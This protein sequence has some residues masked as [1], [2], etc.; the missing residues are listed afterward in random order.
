MSNFSPPS[1]ED[2]P[3]PI[4]VLVVDDNPDHTRL[5]AEFLALSGLFEVVAARDLAQLWQE[6]ASDVFDIILLDYSL[7]DGNGLEALEAL[8]ARG[9]QLPIV[10]V[11]G[12]GDERVAAQAIQRG[13]VD[14]LV[15][16]GDYLKILPALIEKAVRTQALMMSNQLSLEKVRY[17]A[18]LLD[19]IDDAV[20][21]WD[22]NNQLTFW[23]QAAEKLLGWNAVDRIGQSA[24]HY[25]FSVFT[26]PIEPAA[27]TAGGA[28]V[29]R[30]GKRRSGEDLWVN[31][32]V[33]ELVDSAGRLIGYLDISRDITSRKRLE[34]QMIATQAQLTQAT[35]L[36][37]VGALATSV[38]HEM[39]NPL[40]TVIAEAQLLKRLALSESALESTEAIETAGLRSQAA[41]QRLLQHAQGPRGDVQPVCV[42]ETIERALAIVRAYVES[43]SVRVALQLDPDLPSVAGDPRQLEDLWTNLLLLA[44]AAADDDRPHRITIT[45]SRDADGHVLVAVHDDGRHIPAEQ[46]PQIF[47]PALTP[48]G[49][50]R[51]TSLELSLCHEIVERHGGEILASSNPATGTTMTVR[52]LSHE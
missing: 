12:R 22:L 45:S 38:A 3:R 23:N 4:R 48:A 14:Y 7:P 15:K 42:N 8:P 9:Y 39:S 50:G 51:G 20:V 33:T 19:N 37:A 1:E 41:V 5:A 21:V 17:Q 35:R 28:S 26:P 31:S 2:P 24:A 34:A 13:A 47:E 40:T 49:P 44:R 36:A 32:R 52:F 6:L 18:L 46:L 16:T 25:Y 43:A 11:T 10:M 30:H 27:P 29:E